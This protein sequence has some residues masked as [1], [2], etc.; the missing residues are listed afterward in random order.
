MTEYIKLQVKMVARKMIEFGI[1]PIIG[2]LLLSVIFIFGSY[3]LFLKTELAGYIYMFI[4][5]SLVIKLSE[6]RRKDF[7]KSVFSISKYYKIRVMENISVILPFLL[8]LI[9]K[10]QYIESSVLVST[11]ALL[12]FIRIDINNNYTIPTPYYR[13]PFEFLVGFRSTFYLFII[14]CFLVFMSIR[15]G[16]FNLGAFSVI[17]VYFII[18]N[19]YLKLENEYYVWSFSCSPEMF[20]LN[21]IK[22]SLWYST[23]LVI[24]IA[25]ALGLFFSENIYTLLIIIVLGYVYLITIILAKY[26]SYPT[27]MNLPQ[28][29]LIGFSFL[30]PPLL[31]GIIPFFYIRSTKHLN[32]ILK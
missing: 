10:Q 15:V 23:S 32:E 4:A 5:L 27:E 1:N 13:F 24:P 11:S 6:G 8:V 3:L 2:S 22:T 21:K 25:I 7:L 29:I 28:V 19:Y 17:V 16:N 30:F 18:I 12:V 26:S 14:V 20:I 31:L 9:Y